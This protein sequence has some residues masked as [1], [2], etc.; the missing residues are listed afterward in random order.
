LNRAGA[1]QL[2]ED[3]PN[4]NR[5]ESRGRIKKGEI[6]AR[7]KLA[8]KLWKGKQRKSREKNFRPDLTERE[9]LKKKTRLAG[10][11]GDKGRVQRTQRTKWE[12]KSMSDTDGGSA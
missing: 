1:R 8:W 9:S 10:Y 5:G 6:G 4:P 7:A 11:G 12:K 2:T 3:R